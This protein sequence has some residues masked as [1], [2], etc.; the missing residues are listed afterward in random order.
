MKNYIFYIICVFLF[1]ISC[2]IGIYAQCTG[3]TRV[4]AEFSLFKNDICEGEVITIQNTTIENG[5]T[6]MMYIMNWGDG[7]RPDTVYQKQEM[8]HT[9]KLDDLDPCIA[10]SKDLELRLDAIPT[11]CTNFKH[12]VI[13]PVYVNLKPKPKFTASQ[14]ICEQTNVSFG[15]QTCPTQ[16]VRFKWNFGA[17]ST[18]GIDTLRTPSFSYQTPGNYNIQLTATNQCGD[19]STSQAIRVVGQPKA[20]FSSNLNPTTGCLPDPIVSL[21]NTSNQWSNISWRITPFD[22]VNRWKFTDKAMN[23]SSNE[24]NLRFLQAGDYTVTLTADNVCP[25]TDTKTETIK[26]SAPPTIRMMA[27]R[28]SC[29][30]RSFTTRD[31]GLDVQGD[32]STYQWTF[33]NGTPSSFSGRDFGSVRFEQSG[34]ISLTIKS[35]CGDKT[36]SVDVSIANKATINLADNQ[37]TFCQNETPKQLKFSPVGGTWT[38]RNTSSPALNAQGI[39]NPRRLPVGKHTLNYS[40]GTTECP[41]SQSIEIE[42]KD[43]VT[44]RLEKEP[45]GCDKLSYQPKVT[46]RGEISTYTWAFD[47]GTPATASTATP[48]PIEFTTP[49]KKIV[50]ILASGTCGTGRDSIEINIQAKE[51]AKIEGFLAPLCT[52]SSPDTLKINV[53]GGTWDGKGITNKNLGIFDPKTAG[54]G[55]HEITYAKQ[56]GACSINEKVTIQVVQ[57]ESVR[58]SPDTFCINASARPLVVDKPGGKF[59]GKGVDSTSGAFTPSISGVGLQEVRYS[60]VDANNCAV[61]ANANILVEALPTLT[62]TDTLSLCV[63][64]VDVNLPRLLNYAPTPDGGQTRWLGQGITNTNSGIFNAGNLQEGSFSVM[65]TY[66]RNDCEI[67]DSLKIRLVQAQALVI[68][69]DTSICIGEGRLRLRTNLSSGKWSGPGIDQTTGEIDLARASSGNYEYTYIFQEGTNCEQKK[70]VKVNV[71]DLGK[72]LRA[73]ANSSVCF[74]ANEFTLPKGSPEDGF[75][76]GPALLDSITGRIDLRNLKTDSTYTYQYCLRSASVSNCQACKSQTFRIKPKPNAGFAFDGKPCINETFRMRNLSLGAKSYRWNFGDGSTEKTDVE[77]QHRYQN[78]GTYN[79][80]LI[81]ISSEDCADTLTRSLYITTPPVASFSLPSRGGCAPFALE[82]TNQSSGDSITQFWIVGKDTIRGANFGRIMLDRV[83]KDTF[84]KVTLVVENLCGEVRQ[85]DSVQV[86]PYPIVNFGISQDEG[87]SPSTVSFFN[88]TLGNPQSLEWDFGNGQSSVLTQPPAQVYTTGE[89]DITQYTVW[90]RASNQCGRDSLKKTITVFPPNVKAFIEK[91]TF[92][93]CQPFRYRPKGFVT[94]GSKLSWKLIHEGGKSEG[95]QLAQ[96]IFLLDQAG[97]Y[98]LV[99][100]ASNCGTDTDTAYIQVK[101]APK[102]AFDHR[103]YVC[104]GRSIQVINRSAGISGSEWR[105]GNDPNTIRQNSP[106]YT[107]DSVGTYWIKLR[108]FSALNNCPA[109]DSSKVEVIGNPTARFQADRTSGCFPLKVNFK[110]LSTGNGQLQALWDFGDQTSKVTRWDTAHVFQ[111]PGNYI[112]RLRVFDR[113]SCSA[114]TSLLNIFVHDKPQTAFSVLS[115]R[116]C[117]GHDSLVLRNQ[118]RN[119]VQYLWTFQ[120]DTLRTLNARFWPRQAGNSSIQL[121]TRNAFN[122][123]DTLQQNLNV[124]LSPTAVIDSANTQACVNSIFNFNHS[125]RHASS[126]SWSFDNNSATTSRVQHVFRN[127]G[128]Y[129]VVLIARTNNGCPSDTT[130]LRIQVW[131]K[132]K[133]AFNFDKPEACGTPASVLFF[134]ESTGAKGFS[135]TYGDGT[136]SSRNQDEH[137]YQNPGVFNVRLIADNEFL[138]R[139][140]LNKPVDIFGKPQASFELGSNRCAPVG[141]ALINRS[142]SALTYRWQVSNLGSFAKKDTTLRFE[143]PGTYRIKLTAIYNNL[144]R[145]SSEQSITLYQRPKADFTYQAN[146]SPNILGDVQ[147]TDQSTLADRLR[148]EFGD[149]N[150]STANNPLHEYSINRPIEAT[151]IA[152]NDNQGQFVCADSIKKPIQPEWLSRFYAPNAFTPG[153]GAPLTQVFKPTGIGIKKYQIRVFSPYGALVWK[154]EEEG[155]STPTAAWDGRLN[156]EYVPQGAYAWRADV[157]FEDQTKRVFTGTVTVIR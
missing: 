154:A 152:F 61:E 137:I 39:L 40:I 94:P 18:P 20:D 35:A 136:T 106:S 7:T 103:P 112:V 43:S 55:S 151:L 155:I 10:G 141:L 64:S 73:G 78:Q 95:S 8:K 85:V 104:L 71:I 119:A 6:K 21:K 108:V 91:D 47:G 26:I 79:L 34:K 111:R 101:P 80:S 125:S 68:S 126:I 82:V 66:Q 109:E 30:P 135:W 92:E 113:D 110:N 38:I 105:F 46:Y 102:V 114:D 157:E 36:E 88:T 51:A 140:T 90:L 37:L 84:F 4:A 3:T 118:S 107:F 67:R 143:K 32:I 100:S 17:P 48:G 83:T 27:P 116:A 148:W 1:F 44:A 52:G 29:E 16:G 127:A 70:S 28:A 60:R 93:V 134:N 131:P 12:F 87:C 22:T 11:G 86:R 13:K 149:G 56:S 42:V 146:L 120:G 156:G 133:A 50:K 69:R 121:I 124:L 58:L 57:S 81:A 63:S 54:P 147:F 59:F 98:T 45:D 62:L 99:L 74:G 89:K 9:Y 49:G 138:C 23:L 132:P 123:T 122:C 142:T 2:P 15:N 129:Q 96:P 128:Q 5:H 97:R 150:T 77:P 139:D 14:E 75:F 24:I 115:Q 153:Y 41:N 72:D 65:V 145:D 25:G 19:A 31:I 53:T 33:E 130:S 117:L 144:C 76:R